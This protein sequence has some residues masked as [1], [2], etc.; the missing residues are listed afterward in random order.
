MQYKLK[1]QYRLDVVD[2]SNYIV[3]FNG[4]KCVFLNPLVSVLFHSLINDGIEETKTRAMSLLN[5]DE[6]ASNEYLQNII[7]KLN[8]YLDIVDDDTTL[9]RT[10]VRPDSY[11]DMIQRKKDY[12][13]PVTKSDVPQKLKLYMTDYCPR[14]CI[15]CFAGAKQSR[16]KIQIKDTFLSIDRFKEII[17]E[18]ADIG[19]NDIEVSG[20]DPFI[21]SDIFEYIKV[22]VDCFPR[23]WTTSTKSLLTEDD[24]RRLVDIGLKNIQ[25]SID[26]RNERTANKLMGCEGAFAEVSKTLSNLISAGIRVSTNST[27]TS[28]NI[29]DIPDLVHWLVDIGVKEIRNTF[30]YS[31]GNRHLSSLFPTNEQILQYN[32]KILC[33]KQYCE[34]NGVVTNIET[35]DLYRSTESEDKRLFCGGYSNSMSIRYDGSVLFC[36]SLNRCD[37][38][39]AGNLKN[40]G[41]MEVWNSNKL[42]QFSDPM[43]FHEKY[44]GTKCYDCHLYNNCFYKRCYV[45]SFNEY[46]SYFEVDPA[47]PFGVS[48]YIVR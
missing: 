46:G 36:D 23:R 10:G 33:A 13:C 24:V 28:Y 44:K 17:K 5:I 38:F 19:V 30:Y 7:V 48:G 43:Y 18:A 25:V 2:D 22:M 41:I 11:F 1:R 32:E 16:E 4:T 27:I 12:Q 15:Y 8:D 47:C 26:T 31:S 14:K 40:Q 20:G 39:V 34:A 6:T 9:S 42:K 29:A 21:G 3:S 37:D 35:H 45:R